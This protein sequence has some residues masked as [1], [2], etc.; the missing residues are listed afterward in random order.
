MRSIKHSFSEEFDQMPPTAEI[1]YDAK[2]AAAGTKEQ[3]EKEL[4]Q[5][6]A[7]L[8]QQLEEKVHNQGLS[9]PDPQDEDAPTGDI[10]TYDVILRV[11]PEKASQ[12]SSQV[13]NGKKCLVIP[14]EENEYATVNGVN[15]QV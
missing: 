10:R 8:E 1:L 9:I 15:T 12:I 5:K 11:K 14:M 4:V 3:K 6:V 7:I 2:A 13:I